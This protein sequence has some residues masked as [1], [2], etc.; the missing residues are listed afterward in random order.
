MPQPKNQELEFRNVVFETVAIFYNREDAEI[1]LQDLTNEGS[2]TKIMGDPK[3][4]SRVISNLIIN[5]I[6]AV[7][8]GKK[9]QILVKLVF[10]GDNHIKLIIKDNGKGISEEFKTKVFMPNFRRLRLR[11]GDC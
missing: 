10:E 1:D 5:G 7:L 2:S 3:L 8:E 9:P 11:F 6:Q 4:Y